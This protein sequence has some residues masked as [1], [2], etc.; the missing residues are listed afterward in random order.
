MVPWGRTVHPVAAGSKTLSPP[1]GSAKPMPT[2]KPATIPPQAA[3][4]RGYP[5]KLEIRQR[6]RKDDQRK[7]QAG[8]DDEQPKAAKAAKAAEAAKAEDAEL[9]KK[10][11]AVGV[12]MEV[13]AEQDQSQSDDDGDDDNEE[14]EDVTVEEDS[15]TDSDS[16]KEDKKTPE[17]LSD[18]SDCR[19]PGDFQQGDFQAS[20]KPMRPRSPVAPPMPKA[21][22]IKRQAVK[23][24]AKAAATKVKLQVS[25]KPRGQGKPG[26][27]AQGKPKPPKPSCAPAQANST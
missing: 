8:V 12:K 19:L 18:D 27:R 15:E 14:V 9:I 23:E 2:M 11:R 6:K 10:V 21:R 4:R 5:A 3:H 16:D 20:R 24:A 26:P 25:S 13:K 1:S 22:P 17:I 7:Q